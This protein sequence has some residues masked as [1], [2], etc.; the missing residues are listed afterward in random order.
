MIKPKYTDFRVCYE[1]GNPVSGKKIYELHKM[2][3]CSGCRYRV[4]YL[5]ESANC[6]TAT[7][8]DISKIDEVAEFLNNWTCNNG[9]TS[10]KIAYF[11]F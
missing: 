3:K 9:N 5:K 2:C 6:A 8:D 7:T 11:K 4:E 10:L 1:G